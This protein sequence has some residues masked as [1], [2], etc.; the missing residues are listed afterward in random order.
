[1]KRF[2]LYLACLF[3]VTSEP[4]CLTDQQFSHPDYAQAKPVQQPVQHNL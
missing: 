4:G 1:M 3:F 2:L